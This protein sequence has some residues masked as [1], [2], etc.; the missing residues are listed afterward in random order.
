M[1]W[2]K[3]SANTCETQGDV[4]KHTSAVEEDVLPSR[5]E[6]R[7]EVV[8]LWP[9]ERA[10]ETL[11]LRRIHGGD[12]GGEKKKRNA[13]EGRVILRQGEDLK[14]TLELHLRI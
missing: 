2:K 3:K 7:V 12:S 6:E 5:A 4:S 13:M 1:N 11:P 10:A 9:E 8:A 14:A